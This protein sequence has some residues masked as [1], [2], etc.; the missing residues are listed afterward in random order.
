MRKRLALAVAVVGMAM[1]FAMVGCG[2]SS[3][4]KDGGGTDGGGTGGTD[5]GGTGGA[6]PDGGGAIDTSSGVDAHVPDAYVAVDSA[7]IID[8]TIVDAPMGPDAPIAVDSAA[9]DGSTP[10]DAVVAVDT[11]PLVCTETTKFTGGTVTSNRTLTKACSPY[12]IRNDIAVDG[13]ATLTIEPGTTLRF[14]SDVRL[15]VGYSTAGKLVAV[16]NAANPITFTSA[17]TTP[18]AGDWI[19]IVFWG[20]TMNGS[21]IGYAALDYCGSNADACILGSG[22]KANRVSIDHVTFNHVGAG[23]NGIEQKD[24]DSNFTISNCTFNGIPSTPTQQYA[25]SLQAPSFAGIDTSNVFGTAL[26]EMRGGTIRTKT[27]WKN[28]GT[29]VAVTDALRIEGPATPELSIAAGSTFKFAADTYVWIGYTDAGSLVVTGTATSNVTFTSLNAN[30]HA[31]DWAGVTLWTGNAT[32][33]YATIS[34]AGSGKGAISV[35]SDSATLVVENSTLSYSASYGIGIPCGA[36]TSITNTGNVFSNNA[37][38]NVGPGPAT[39][40][41][42]CP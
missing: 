36:T 25:I 16:G 14:E 20:N 33:K 37:D 40:T 31:G 22:V 23:S 34:Y 5:G 9:V 27:A 12:T 10:I 19:G 41:A 3:G 30:P 18:G 39:G 17:N 29:T 35:E 2:D 42:A 28:I 4:D 7:D 11:A 6:K 26:V 13:N 8:A 15:W 21:A 24:A 38:G 1:P 32:F